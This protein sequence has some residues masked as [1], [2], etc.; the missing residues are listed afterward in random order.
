[1]IEFEKIYRRNTLHF[2]V[3]VRKDIHELYHSLYGKGNNTPEQWNIFVKSLKDGKY[4]DKI[5]L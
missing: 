5:T 4:N 3:C 1:M 2:G